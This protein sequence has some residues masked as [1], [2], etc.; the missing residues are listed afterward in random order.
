VTIDGLRK[1]EREDFSEFIEGDEALV[2][3]AIGVLICDALSFELA[4]AGEGGGEGFFWDWRDGAVCVAG[5]EKGFEFFE[6]LLH[7]LDGDAFDSGRGLG[8]FEGAG[9]EEFGAGRILLC[10]C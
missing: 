10:D 2:V 5:C 3:C 6:A 9:L 8:G 7:A 4:G 1:H